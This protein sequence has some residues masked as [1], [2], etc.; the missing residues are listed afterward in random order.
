[1]GGI[2][3]AITGAGAANSANKGYQNAANESNQLDQNIYNEIK[4]RN[5]PYV[6][7]GTGAVNEL[8][9]LEG[10]GG[11]PQSG[12]TG[13]EGS[14][15][16][17][18]TYQDLY[19]DPSYGFRLQQ[20]SNALQSSGAARGTLNSGAGEIALQNYGQDY[21][22]QEYQNAFNRYQTQNQNVYARLSGLSGIGQTANA[23]DQSAGESYAG[24]YNNNVW[25]AANASA[26]KSGALAGAWNQ[27]LGS[28]GNIAG[29]IFGGG[30]T[31][32]GIFSSEGAAASSAQAA[33][34]NW[35]QSSPQF[36]TGLYGPGY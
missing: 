35:N 29:D 28:I 33:G 21:A 11:S 30:S 14:L 19:Q 20:G 10:V 8:A 22:S 6:S 26:Q 18:F 27:G 7:A 13:A 5:S 16:A 4:D 36:S 15:N 1:M 23:A 2:V 34:V 24:Q 31:S 32:D 3:G 25:N 9:Y 17:P 12:A